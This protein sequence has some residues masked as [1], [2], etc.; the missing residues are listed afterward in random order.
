M[1][2]AKCSMPSERKLKT[3]CVK[4]T[5]M[6]RPLVPAAAF[7]ALAFVAAKLAILGLPRT[8]A[9]AGDLIAITAE[10]LLVAIVFGAAGALALRASRSRPAL[11]AALWRGFLLAGA[12][13]V[14]YA[15]LSV[16]IYAYL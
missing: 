10:D 2:N 7:L 16:G 1:L 5:L 12:L 15:V 4:V 14:L 3:G 8:F 11:E 9:S 6:S 13:A